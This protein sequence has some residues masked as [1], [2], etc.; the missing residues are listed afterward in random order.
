MAKK[1]QSIRYLC[2]ELVSIVR[3]LA[4][5]PRV[6]TGN[7]EEIGESSAL[8]LAERAIPAGSE[9][10][11]ECQMRELK[12][13]T[14]SCVVDEHLG[15]FVEIQLDSGSRWSPLWF[16]PRHLLGLFGLSPQ[17]AVRTPGSG[18]HRGSP[19]CGHLAGVPKVFHAGAA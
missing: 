15:F 14:R 19:R 9:V 13:V 16:A 18:N 12:G 8:V 10:R 4:E 2:S 3:P 11:I 7:L 5:G 6:L 1:I 17:L